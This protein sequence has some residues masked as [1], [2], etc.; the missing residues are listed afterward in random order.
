MPRITNIFGIDIYMYADDHNPPH[1]HARYCDKEAQYLI[2]TSEL[3]SGNLP[4]KQNSL[5]IKFIEAYK[6]VLIEM[7]ENQKIKKL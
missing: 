4:V 5:V 2:K 3:L 7:W 1:L 6:D